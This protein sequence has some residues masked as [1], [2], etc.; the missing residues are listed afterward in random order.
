MANPNK[1]QFGRLLKECI[2]R[3][4]ITQEELALN[5]G[6]KGEAS[7]SRYIKGE[8]L[9]KQEVLE[10]TVRF[11]RQRGVTEDI[12]EKFYKYTGY[13]E[14]TEK[15]NPHIAFLIELLEGKSSHREIA[16]LIIYLL[17]SIKSPILK[18]QNALTDLR[19]G[20]NVAAEE[21]LEKLLPASTNPFVFNDKLR[22]SLLISTADSK[23][24]NGKLNEAIGILKSAEQQAEHFGEAALKQLAELLMLRGNIYRRLSNWDTAKSDYGSSYRA[25]KDF[26]FAS[27]EKQDRPRAVLE[28][29]LAGTH[30]FQSQ[31]KQALEHIDRSLVICREIQDKNEELKALQHQAWAYFLLGQWEKSLLIHYDILSALAE[32]GVHPI[33]LAKCQRYLADTLGKCGLYEEAITVYNEAINNLEQFYVDRADEKD[34]LVYGTVELGIGGVYRIRDEKRL[35]KRY[36]DHSFDIHTQMGARYH[37]ALTRYELGLLAIANK[38]FDIAKQELTRAIHLFTELDNKYY[39]IELNLALGAL[40][41]SRGHYAEARAHATSSMSMSR[42]FDFA[43]LAVEALILLADINQLMPD[44]LSPAALYT[45]AIQ[46]ASRLDPFL[47]SKTLCHLAK[48]KYELDKV[49]AVPQQIVDVCNILLNNGK[50]ISTSKIGTKVD[51]ER[52]QAEIS[53]VRSDYESRLEDDQFNTGHALIIGI[54]SYHNMTHLSKATI[55]AK[56]LRDV[57]IRSGYPPQNVELLLDDQANRRQI[58]ASFEKLARNVSIDDTVVIFFSGHGARPT[59]GFDPGEYLCPVDATWGNMLGTA[60]SD[61]NLTKAIQ[62]ISAKHVAVLLDACHSGGV[63][64]P[65]DSEVMKAGLSEATYTKL[66]AEKG[67]VVIA[68]CRPDEVSWELQGMRNGLFTH[69]LLEGL[70]GKA[71]DEKGTVRVFRLF[72]YLSES[73][74]KVKQQQHPLFK[75][76]IEKDFGILKCKPMNK[77]NRS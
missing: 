49:D 33:T 77:K 69:Y 29:K 28:R 23:R 61:E 39:L 63:G 76:S 36:L 4:G 67:C 13:E 18:Y 50:K 70:R 2:D 51:I 14:T 47:L 58:N 60:I 37:E 35:A 42:N 16:E 12:L 55:D 11:F 6:L 46:D 7:I 68:S 48:K 31:P 3:T 9:P 41:L 54:D 34:M 40:E 56:D 26:E 30:L 32:R 62:S 45:S 44:V 43:A 71:S 75:G 74:P 1:K 72:S 59:A 53:A 17:E 19:R 38:E 8:N 21:A 10:N 64:E 27:G 24:L 52:L 57:L 73:I 66:T 22:L 25:F 5:V 20:D 15:T 65:K